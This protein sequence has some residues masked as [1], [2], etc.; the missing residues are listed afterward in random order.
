LINPVKQGYFGFQSPESLA[1][2][3]E[4]RFM[5]PVV[6]R[7]QLGSHLDIHLPW[8]FSSGNN[9]VPFDDNFNNLKTALEKLGLTLISTNLPIEI[10]V[11]EKAH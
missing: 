8:T 5:I 11:V 1:Q 3:L 9:P 2:F 7:T 6:D 10:L 4:N